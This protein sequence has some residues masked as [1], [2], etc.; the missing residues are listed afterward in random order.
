MPTQRKRRRVRDLIQSL[1]GFPPEGIREPFKPTP[2]QWTE[3][4]PFG[5]GGENKDVPADSVSPDE[6]HLI[7]N[8][9]IKRSRIEPA[10]GYS[11]VGSPKTSPV[12]ILDIN[13]YKELDG[14][15]R[16]IRLDEDDLQH[17]AGSSWSTVS[18]NGDAMTGDQDDKIR[19]AMVLNTF[20]WVNGVDAP[21]K[22]SQ[23][24]STY[25]DLT[26]DSNA[27]STARFVVPF[28]ERAVFADIG[29][30]TS[31]DTQRVEWSVSGDE[32]DFTGTGA[33]G[34]NLYDAQG[35]V[36]AD[37][38]MGLEVFSNF[39]VVLRQRSIWLGQ[40]TG[41]ARAP[42]RFNSALQGYGV[43]ARDSVQICGS[44]GIIFLG[45]DNVY[46]YNPQ[47]REPIPVG[48]PI[49]DALFNELDRSKLDKV[50]SLY[51]PDEN[52]YWLIIPD[53]DDT[54][55]TNAY[56]LSVDRIQTED[57]FVWSERDLSQ[58]PVTAAHAGPTAGLGSS[59]GNRRSKPLIGSDGGETFE[60]D[61]S[62]TDDD[63]TTVTGVFESPQFTAGN[64]LIDLR[65]LDI[66]YTKVSGGSASITV[67]FSEDGGNSFG[68]QSTY[69]LPV[70]EE[71]VEEVSLGVP[72][73]VYDR[74]VMFRVQVDADQGI[75]LIG[76][77]LGFV[78][79]G[80]LKMQS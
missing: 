76:Y 29:T 45:N 31:R 18:G 28:A 23:G 30:G 12:E 75:E 6:A 72:S 10:W 59:F 16:L 69:A 20:V 26:A 65:R 55:A 39:L 71:A 9:K 24:D 32:T 37:D 21:K 14:T 61:E 50:R 58:D 7:E 57:K 49:R 35:N 22:W 64:R 4:F 42:I 74:S 70:T 46:L 27:P 40:R 17:W 56:I 5:T 53:S 15:S 66:A 73:G 13:L 80:Q 48:Q 2:L 78:P 67:D 52:E 68:T 34:A 8:Y 77:R 19:S 11:E 44:L 41:D 43:I 33:G 47:N 60:I 36:P 63:S 38:I 79:R 54:W 51:D 1:Q 62:N 3:R 25:S